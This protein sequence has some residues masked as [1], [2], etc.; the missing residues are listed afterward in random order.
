MLHGAQAVA[1]FSQVIKHRAYQAFVDTFVVV[2]PWVGQQV[3]GDLFA[4]QL[5][6]SNVVVEGA[7]QIVAI[8]P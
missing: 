8:L 1:M 3:A 2:D 6:K 5:I 4:D 7:D